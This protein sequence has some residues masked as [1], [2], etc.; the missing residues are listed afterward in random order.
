MKSNKILSVR[1]QIADV[2]RSDI[3]SGELEPN[4]KLNEQQLAER[5]GTSRGPI[6]DVLIKLTKEGLLVSK[7]N[8]GSSVSSPL[9]PELQK[10]SI[11]I[12]RKIEEHAV[13]QLENNIS[14][15]D[16]ARMDGIIDRMQE[17]FDKEEFTD[18]TKTD[19]EFH[20]Y[21]V[22]LAGGEDLTNLWY[23]VVLRMR[24][25]YQRIRNSQTLVD[26][27]RHIV[28]A[29]RKNDLKLAI[30]SIRKNIK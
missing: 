3:I 29:L 20:K 6:R 9:T 26:E 12:R 11:D 4:T 16:L 15:A 13:K 27:H 28:D 17:H 21:F 25:N 22:G 19:I 2:L 24:M 10:L 30:S 1:E 8:V 14:E 23:P 7:D 5:F 18:L